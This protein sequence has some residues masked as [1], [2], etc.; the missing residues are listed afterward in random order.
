MICGTGSAC[1]CD[2]GTVIMWMA[3]NA[4][5]NLKLYTLLN[6]RK[7]F[8][9]KNVTAQNLCNSKSAQVQKSPT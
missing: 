7:R 3:C 1:A 9:A 2:P 4:G 5:V 8:I 6:A